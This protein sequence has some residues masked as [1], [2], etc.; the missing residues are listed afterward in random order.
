MAPSLAGLD[1]AYL[2]VLVIGLVGATIWILETIVFEYHPD[3]LAFVGAFSLLLVGVGAA[4]LDPEFASG[5]TRILYHGVAM[6]GSGL[7]FFAMA[8]FRRRMMIETGAEGEDISLIG[9]ADG[10]AE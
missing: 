10:G 6:M 3:A 2:A 8:F 9:G 4:A 1:P 5:T 7:A